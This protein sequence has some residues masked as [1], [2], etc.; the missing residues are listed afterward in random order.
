MLALQTGYRLSASMAEPTKEGL[1]RG[2]RRWELAAIAVNGIIGAG[3]FGLPSEVFARIGAYS[4][5]AFSACTLVVALII[6]CFA[7]VGSRF[8]ENGGPYLYCRTAFGRFVGFQINWLT[9]TTRIIA[10]AS[11]LVAVAISVAAASGPPTPRR[12][13]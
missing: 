2:I 10:H 3:I 13:G 9:W 7:E 8:S 12:T 4:L 6:L 11:V 5:F 1:V